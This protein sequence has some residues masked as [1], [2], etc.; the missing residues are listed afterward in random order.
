[1]PR[2]F[3]SVYQRVT[4]LKCIF[5]GTIIYFSVVSCDNGE[6][7]CNFALGNR[8]DHSLFPPPPSSVGREPEGKRQIRSNT[9]VK[10]L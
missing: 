4:S 7:C 10:P 2:K 5:F 3:I 8:K 6:N 9:V 1:M